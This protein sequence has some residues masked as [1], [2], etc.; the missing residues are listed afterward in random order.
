MFHCL[1]RLLAHA[2]VAAFLAP[3]IAEAQNFSDIW[4]NPAEPGWG[5][6]IAD[7]ETNLFVVLYAYRED[8]QPVWYTVPGG[9]L[10]ADRRFFSGDVYITRGPPYAM[11]FDPGRVA[12]TKVGTASFD[13]RPPGMAA[14]AAALSY[15]INGVS[16]ATPIERLAFGSATPGWGRDF[17]EL[18]YNPG[19]SGWGLALAQHGD[20][21]FGVWYTHDADGEP[22]WMILPGVTFTGASAFNGKLYTATGPWFGNPA[23]DPA[24]VRLT[25]VGEGSVSVSLAKAD[26]CTGAS[27][28]FEP[29]VTRAPL[30]TVRQARL[31]CPL[32]FGTPNPIANAPAPAAPAP[33]TCTGTYAASVRVPATCTVGAGTQRAFSGS[34]TVQGIDWTRTG[35]QR[36]EMRI[37]GFLAEIW[38]SEVVFGPG[39]IISNPCDRNDFTDFDDATVVFDMGTDA[40]G[41]VVGTGTIDIGIPWT[42]EVDFRVPGGIS[43]N[44]HFAYRY[45]EGEEYVGSGSF[46]CQFPN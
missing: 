9:T 35:Q 26:L 19:E 6:T 37:T 12:T 32:P 34:I 30:G 11:T 24:A 20:N 22:L 18:W 33:K 42:S 29:L 13:F 38:S 31:V 27:A 43:V 16:K 2:L 10:S 36:G 7:H 28:T 25:E 8:G 5:V 39:G 14:G 4:L 41:T 46:A 44:G 40:T 45:V 3:C 1:R 23:F 17:T 21:V 15:T